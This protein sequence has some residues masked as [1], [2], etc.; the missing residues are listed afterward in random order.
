M[1][2][3]KRFL[4]VEKQAIVMLDNGKPCRHCRKQKTIALADHLATWEIPRALIIYAGED[5]DAI[6]LDCLEE[7]LD[8]D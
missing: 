1:R 2:F 7:T 3:I 8:A 5:V 4:I 6:C